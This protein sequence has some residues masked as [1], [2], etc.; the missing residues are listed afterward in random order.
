MLL[1][2]LV[3]R[4]LSGHESWLEADFSVSCMGT[5]YALYGV[6][7]LVLLALVPI[8]VPSVLLAV[9]GLRQDARAQ[10]RE[11][12]RADACAHTHEFRFFATVCLARV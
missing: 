11:R 2:M 7:A 1:E 10:A 6:L 12:E 3:C 9:M 4:S 5:T 8:G